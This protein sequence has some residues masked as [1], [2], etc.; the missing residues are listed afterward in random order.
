MSSTRAGFGFVCVLGLC[1]A[2]SSRPSVLT[3][4]SGPLSLEQA[5][6]YVL[7]LVNRDRKDQGLPEV[8]RDRVAERAAQEHADD[9][10]HLGY[11]AHWGSDGSVPEERYTLAGGTHFVQE[12]AACFGDSVTRELVKNPTFLAEHLEKIQAA[13]MGERPPADGHRRN[14]LK[15]THTSLGVGLAQPAGIPEPC[16]AHEFVD[17]RGDYDSIPKSAKPGASLHVEGDVKEP[18]EFGGVGLSR[19]ELAKPQSA[20]Q[21]NLD[22]PGAGAVRLVFPEGLQDAER[23]RARRQ[24]L[25][26]R[27]AAQRRP[28]PLRRQR[29]G[30]LSRR[31]QSAGD[32]EPAHAR[33]ALSRAHMRATYTVAP[34]ASNGAMSGSNGCA[35]SMPSK[36]V[37]TI[38]I[39]A[40]PSRF[41]SRTSASRPRSW[42]GTSTRASSSPFGPTFTN[43][44]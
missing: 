8:E 17:E 22:V 40:A 25:L 9:M 27:R 38:K 18:V 13:F 15:E 12:N 29:L 3:R 4:P 21:L 2:C 1:A 42:N 7:A 41:C 34:W 30:S 35:R 26:H 44:H 10:A 5:R 33:S 24:A 36:L 14:I 23:G 37:P 28:R 19:I 16:L 32:G 6:D 39:A 20:A 11:T 31:R 43:C